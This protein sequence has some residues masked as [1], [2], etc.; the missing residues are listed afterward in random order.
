MEVRI[1]E[2]PSDPSLPRN[3][4]VQLETPQGLQFLRSAGLAMQALTSEWRSVPRCNLAPGGQAVAVPIERD[5]LTAVFI[6]A[7]CVLAGGLFVGTLFNREAQNIN[8]RVGALKT[9]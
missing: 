1:A 9:T 4:A 2:L 3:V 5:R 6:I 7:L 8:N